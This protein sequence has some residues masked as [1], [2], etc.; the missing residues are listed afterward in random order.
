MLPEKFH[1]PTERLDLQPLPT[2]ALRRKD[3]QA[4][5]TSFSHFNPIQTQVRTRVPAQGLRGLLL[6]SAAVSKR[7]LVMFGDTIRSVAN[8]ASSVCRHTSIFLHS[9]A[10]VHGASPQSACVVSVQV[11]STLFGSNDNVLVCAPTGSGKTVCA[12]FAIM[13]MLA[14]VEAKRTEAE[15]DDTVV[16]PP[17]RAVYVASLPLIVQQTFAVWEERLGGLGLKVVQLSGEQQV[18]TAPEPLGRHRVQATL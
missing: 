9:L 18:R 16:V 1:P 17:L 14:E 10:A 2:S 15:S 3:F 5:Y 13:H 6:S 11:F 12:E 8:D 7:S 4:L